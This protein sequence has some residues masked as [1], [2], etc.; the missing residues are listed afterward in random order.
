[1][2][3]VSAKALAPWTA[4]VRAEA[5]RAFDAAHPGLTWAPA[6][7]VI[8]AL[9]EAASIADV[10]AA[11]PPEACGV[12]VDTLVV[13]DGS[14]DATAA[15][16]RAA[17]ARVVRLERNCGH[18]V[19]LRLGY[20]L[21]RERGAAY[22]VTLDGDGQWDPAE[23]PR[24]LA[25]VVAGEADLVL[26]SRVLGSSETGAALR[27]T[28]VHVFAFLVRVLTG[29]RVTDTSTGFRAMRAEITAAVPQRQVQY[30][31]SELLIGAIARGYRVAERPVVMR[32]RT[33][34]E[35]K[36][37]HDFLYGLRYARVVLGTWWRERGADPASSVTL[38]RVA[39]SG[40][41]DALHGQNSPDAS[42]SNRH[43]S[44]ADDR[45]E[46]CAS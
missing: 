17:G 15:V 18:G 2:S 25:P 43:G 6:V 30:Q 38:H 33:A 40:M 26:G 3:V 11:V 42:T 28:G 8:A 41:A 23:L 36:K 10:V 32:R 5:V 27:Q 22:I 39:Q 45:S 37:G 19:A 7:A 20:E 16:A 12:Q 46:P 44:A 21:A 31:T 13:D 35:S 9:D 29:A 24:V 1:V 34:G 4:Q 14:S